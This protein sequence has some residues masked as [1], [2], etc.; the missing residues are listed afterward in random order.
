MRIVPLFV[1][2]VLL[3]LVACS[4]PKSYIQNPGNQLVEELSSHRVVML[5][6]FYHELAPSNRSFINFLNTWLERCRSESFE[7]R[8][9][10]LFLEEDEQVA[11]YIRQYLKT[12]NLNP[13]LDFALPSTSLERLEFY[14]DLKRIVEQIESINKTLPAS[15]AVALDIQGPESINA[16][17]PSMSDSSRQSGSMW[18]VNQRD[19]LTANNAIAYIKVHPEQKAV[20]FYGAAH[21]IKR[22]VV[23]NVGG[24]LPG[25]QS[26]GNYLAF[27]LKQ[28]FGQNAVFTVNQLP[29][30]RMSGS[31]ENVPQGDLFFKSDDVPWNASK[32]ADNNLMPTN[33]DAF[34]L[35]DADYCP[36]HPLGQ[37]F[38]ARI[39]DACIQKLEQLGSHRTGALAGKYYEQALRALK[40]ISSESFS[41]PDQ[42]KTWRASHLLKPVD[43]LQSKKFREALTAAYK[44]NR[45]QPGK[46]VF[47][48]SLGFPQSLLGPPT[49]SDSSWD[50]Q[51][52]ATIPQTVFLNCIGIAM[53]G[54]PPERLSARECLAQF[55]GERFDEPDMYLKWWRKKYHN[56][57][58]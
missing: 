46:L 40:F 13:F 17:D 41:D 39:V 6:D 22:T 52:D 38:S 53:I 26:I 55:S 16:F 31:L 37:I 29:R 51:L 28:E 8:K 48:L 33:F 45:N 18:F 11:G 27:Y 12:G 19:S 56:A 20:F 54:S 35:R 10:V 47:L 32:I 9:L 25:G 58:Y 3:P 30:L 21:L 24:D 43:E 50:A 4:Q 49:P 34:I 2:M 36:S 7:S 44:G 57:T 5:A 42:W 14:A 15:K 1:S 23:K